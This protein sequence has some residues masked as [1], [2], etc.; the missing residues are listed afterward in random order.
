VLTNDEKSTIYITFTS[1]TCL[2]QFVSPPTCYSSREAWTIWKGRI[3]VMEMV[4]NITQRVLTSRL[5]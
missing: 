3:Q 2:L 5:L 4:E 1:I